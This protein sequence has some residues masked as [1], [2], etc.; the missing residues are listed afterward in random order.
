MAVPAGVALIGLGI[1]LCR[2]QTSTAPET[3]PSINRLEHAAAG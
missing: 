1:S 2:D 3:A